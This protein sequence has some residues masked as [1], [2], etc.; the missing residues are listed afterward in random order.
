MAAAP[1]PAGVRVF[2]TSAYADAEPITAFRTAAAS[3]KYGR[4]RVT[5]NPAEA[6]LILFI[7]NSH[8]KDDPFFKKLKNHP[9]VRQY[10]DKVFMYNP[11]DLP[12][13]V[14]P[15]L[16]ACMRARLFDPAHVAACSYI[17]KINDFIRCD[18]GTEPTHLYSFYGNLR[19]PVRR[20]LGQ[21][22]HPRG[23]VKSW[24]SGL[25]RD[26]KPKAPQLEYADLLAD[27][28]FILCPRGIGTSSARLFETMQAGRV[29]V[30]ISDDWVRP[31]GP[32]WDELAV[33]VP[34][35]QVAEIPRLLE[36]A[37]ARWPG[38]ARRSRAA[39]E[40]FFAPD[41]IFHYFVEQLVALQHVGKGMKLALTLY[42]GA[43]FSKYYFRAKVLQRAKRFVKRYFRSG[44][45]QPVKSQVAAAACQAPA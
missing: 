13:L 5:D 39:W 10:P 21:L 45:E 27:S 16:Y 24:T 22:H 44:A 32:A 14:L 12:W 29:P 37:E 6:D 43:Q 30:I 41:A 17:E 33:F 1:Q 3:D 28:K 25:Y 18:F 31:R 40:E 35:S 38:M 36:Q 20:E 19:M 7:E 34:E 26:D 15:G 4:H 23:I 8:Y 9:L 2:I 11:H 42:H